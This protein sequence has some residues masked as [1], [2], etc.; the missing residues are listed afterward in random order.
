M[1][2]QSGGGDFKLQTLA[3]DSFRQHRS[4]L[5]SMSPVQS[6]SESSPQ[7]LPPRPRL[8]FGEFAS[9]PRAVRKDPMACS[10]GCRVSKPD[11]LASASP[12]CVNLPIAQLVVNQDA[13]GSL[14]HSGL[15][16]FPILTSTASCKFSASDLSP[17]DES[18]KYC[19]IGYIAGKNLGGP[20]SVFGRPLILQIMPEF[21]DF[22]PPD[23]THVPIWVRFPNLPIRCWT[24]LCLSK[25][26]SVLG[27]PLRC[28]APTIRKT[29]LSFA[30]VLIEVDMVNTLPDLIDVQL[31]NGG[32]ILGQRV[33][34]E[35][36]P[37]FCRSCDSMGHS[38]SSCKNGTSKRKPSSSD[39]HTDPSS[40]SVMPPVEHHYQPGSCSLGVPVVPQDKSTESPTFGR[41]SSLGCKRHKVI[42]INA[43]PPPVFPGQTSHGL[44]ALRHFPSCSSA[45]QDTQQINLQ[46]KSSKEKLPP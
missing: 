10:R 39:S 44:P 12:P 2:R 46:Q 25:L 13:P 11:G 31:P 34:Y 36:R 17:S 3:R 6:D 19:L 41:Q 14:P 9:T 28:D 27:K 16:H 38:A 29:K 22:T 8:T 23:F 43:M 18:L 42:P 33:I 1:E 21:F 37:R 24:P 30:R 5:R 40:S 15:V 35:C 32:S 7:A 20:Y 26:A 45:P 4:P